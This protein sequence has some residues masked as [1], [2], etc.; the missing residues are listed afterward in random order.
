MGGIA[1]NVVP[2]LAVVEEYDPSTD[3]WTQ[4]ADM[5]TPRTVLAVGII[6]SRIYAIGGTSVVQRP[7][8]ATV[9]VYEPATDTWMESSKMP[10]ARVF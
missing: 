7:G 1:E 5:P 3:T 10:T 8:L 6:D 9:E 2:V 4:K